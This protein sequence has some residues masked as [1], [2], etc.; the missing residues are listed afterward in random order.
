MN[1][2][3]IKKIVKLLKQLE[4]IN[5]K[6]FCSLPLGDIEGRMLSNAISLNVGLIAKN[7]RIQTMIRVCSEET[8]FIACAWAKQA[9]EWALGER[10]DIR[11]FKLENE[12]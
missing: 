7:Y 1:K 8:P 10:E 3:K 6:L 12:T 4:K 2:T 11:G 5:V 9:L